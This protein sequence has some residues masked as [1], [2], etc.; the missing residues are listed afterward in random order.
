VA[1]AE[2]RD[3]QVLKNVEKDGHRSMSHVQV[4]GCGGVQDSLVHSL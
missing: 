4:L 1:H 2:S 3:L